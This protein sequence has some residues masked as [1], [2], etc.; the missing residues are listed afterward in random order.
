MPSGL[1]KTPRLDLRTVA[2][3]EGEGKGGDLTGAEIEEVGESPTTTCVSAKMTLL[4]LLIGAEVEGSD[5]G[6]DR[7]DADFEGTTEGPAT[8]SNS[9][10]T[11]LL[12]LRGVLGENPGLTTIGSKV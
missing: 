1:G 4:D 6:G 7:I 12:D 2:E 9:G 10:K 11:T 5:K 3:V 8:T